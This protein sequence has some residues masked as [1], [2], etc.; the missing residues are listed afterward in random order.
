[1]IQHFLQYY[2]ID[3]LASTMSLLMIYSLGSGRRVGFTFGVSANLSWIIFASLS[4]SAPIL[5]SNLIF[6][7]L[8]I[9]GW[10]AWKPKPTEATASTFRSTSRENQ[11]LV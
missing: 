3:W 2:G 5:F 10:C 11:S 1:M 7:M 4:H 8:N 6:L 9:R